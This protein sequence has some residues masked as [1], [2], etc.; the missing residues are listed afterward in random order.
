MEFPCYTL[1]R[2][3]M[4]F[5]SSTELNQ[6]KALTLEGKFSGEADNNF[7]ILNKVNSIFKRLQSIRN[8]ARK[9]FIN[10]TIHSP[11][12]LEKHPSESK[13][14][15]EAGSFCQMAIQEEAEEEKKSILTEKEFPWEVYTN[16]KSVRN[17]NLVG[18]N[19][20]NPRNN[21]ECANQHAKWP[22]D[23]NT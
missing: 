10:N 17:S 16:W 3:D 7:N 8:H 6:L 9:E 4:E 13:Y 14:E 11:N 20:N 19:D 12:I 15:N 21:Y 22:E 1:T 5:S 2:K 23:I 18:C